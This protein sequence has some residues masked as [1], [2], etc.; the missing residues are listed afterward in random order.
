MAVAALEPHFAARLCLTVG[1]TLPGCGGS[2]GNV[3]Q[4]L[5]A[6]NTLLFT[7]AAH[8]ALAQFFKT[9]TCEQLDALASGVDLPLHTL[10]R[11]DNAATMG[12]T[13]LSERNS[14][15]LQAMLIGLMTLRFTFSK[16]C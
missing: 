5:A 11:P 9:Q 6:V 8:R 4:R 16:F 10:A 7:P 1:L 2:D 12:I 15:V 13:A 14:C 3:T